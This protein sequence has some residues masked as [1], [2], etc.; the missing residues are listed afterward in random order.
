MS[1][2]INM[3]FMA[4]ELNINIGA[5]LNFYFVQPKFL[6]ILLVIYDFYKL[7]FMYF[8][9]TQLSKNYFLSIQIAAFLKP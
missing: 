3:P 4:R 7:Y 6:L 8:K 9:L 1:K 5:L 2:I